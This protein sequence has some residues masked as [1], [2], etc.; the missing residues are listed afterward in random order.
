MFTNKQ[1]DNTVYGGLAGRDNITNNIISGPVSPLGTLNKKF[2]NEAVGENHDSEFIETLQHYMQR[3]VDPDVRGLA[4]KLIEGQRDDL[5]HWAEQLKEKMFMRIMRFQTSPA[6]Q[7]IFAYVMA[8]LHTRFQLEVRPYIQKNAD[9]TVI[10]SLVQE[11][12]IQPVL[13]SL[14][15]NVLTL[16]AADLLGLIF[17]MCG[18]C[19]IRWDKC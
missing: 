17:Y 2:K 15:D 11:R 9:R 12:V 10:D 13:T 5:V 8:D 16:S 19:H 3:A 7:D 4:A 6:A 14:E 1:T 18:N